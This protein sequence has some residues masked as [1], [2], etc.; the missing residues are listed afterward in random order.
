M[1]KKLNPID[2]DAQSL[3]LH[4]VQCEQSFEDY[5]D[6][7]IKAARANIKKVSEGLVEN[8]FGKGKRK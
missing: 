7:V 1:T 3:I 4:A 8:E 6:R 2:I 5:S